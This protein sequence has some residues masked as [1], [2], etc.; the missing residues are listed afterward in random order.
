VLAQGV[1]LV[2]VRGLDLLARYVGELGLGYQGF[3]LGADELLLQ[4][5]DLGRVGLLV[6]ELG[7]L[8]GDLLLSC[9]EGVS[10]SRFW[11]I[12]LHEGLWGMTYCLC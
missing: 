12:V 8:V 6:L 9:L 4:D 2:R 1:E 11:N 3:G 7:D 5:D 10:E